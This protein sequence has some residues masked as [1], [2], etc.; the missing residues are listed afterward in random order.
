[1]MSVRDMENLAPTRTGWRLVW[2]LEMTG[3]DAEP[4][5]LDGLDG[6]DKELHPRLPSQVDG[7]V[8]L[9]L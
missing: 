3:G 6:L 8:V 5:D 9:E 1:M 4:E 2:I 7:A